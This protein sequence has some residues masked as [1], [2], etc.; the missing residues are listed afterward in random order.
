MERFHLLTLAFLLINIP[1]NTHASFQDLAP[2]RT[3][4]KSHKPFAKL[5]PVPTPPPSQEIYI[6]T[7]KK[8]NGAP[9]YS[10]T[11][12]PAKIGTSI[13]MSKIPGS[14]EY[15]IRRQVVVGPQSEEEKL[16]RLQKRLNWHSKQLVIVAS[17]I[18]HLE[19]EK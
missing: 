11:K 7:N 15:T 9:L 19:K 6:A 10:K 2:K 14:P 8:H 4:L 16:N 13:V 12:N 18:A 5:Q 1:Q 3:A 17:Q